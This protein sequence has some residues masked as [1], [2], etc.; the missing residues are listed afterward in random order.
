MPALELQLTPGSWKEESPRGGMD[1]TD[2]PL[3][4]FTHADQQRGEG[5]FAKD[6]LQICCLLVHVVPAPRGCFG[7]GSPKNLKPHPWI[8]DRL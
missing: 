1:A 7:R 4:I 3:E 5:R 2:T 8:K 6:L